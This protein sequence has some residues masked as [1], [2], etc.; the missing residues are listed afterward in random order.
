MFAFSV[1]CLA[2]LGAAQQS[3]QLAAARVLGPQWR[4]MSRSAG[5][6]FSGTVLGVEAQP[7]KK[8]QPLPLILTKFR[9][10]R[11]I[12]GVRP[13]ETLTVR[14]WAG[15]WSMHRAMRSGQR[16]LIFLYPLSR[17]GLTSP[18]N[19]P[20]GQVALDSHGE[21][22]QS[23][24][25]ADPRARWPP[26]RIETAEQVDVATSGAKALY[27]KRPRIAALK[28][29]A[30]QSPTLVPDCTAT[31]PPTTTLRQLERA[32]LSARKN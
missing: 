30:T 11:A 3:D 19:G 7:V 14:E 25:P 29:C 32:L 4:Q 27:D 5:M 1:V 18:V 2:T 15:A 17:L 23:L 8:G 21:I 16:M 6:V 24:P 28:R 10:D 20:A 13:G 9:V 26:A 31:I 12:V 22:A